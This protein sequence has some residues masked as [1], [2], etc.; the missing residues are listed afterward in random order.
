LQVQPKTSELGTRPRVF[1]EKDFADVNYK[2]VRLTRSQFEEYKKTLIGRPVPPQ[3]ITDD[4]LF[5][6]GYDGPEPWVQCCIE[7]PMPNWD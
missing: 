7:E 4:E 1:I 5:A 2:E 6:L 3:D